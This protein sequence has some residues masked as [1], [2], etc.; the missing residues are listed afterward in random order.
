MNPERTLRQKRSQKRTLPKQI[1]LLV[2]IIK[3][4]VDN[5]KTLFCQFIFSP[6]PSTRT[7]P[8]PQ[9]RPRTPPG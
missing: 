7:P 2:L 8:Q 1:E 4:P 6:A 9:A 5:C 3:Y